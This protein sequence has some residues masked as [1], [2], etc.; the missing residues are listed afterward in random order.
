VSPLTALNWYL[1][2]PLAP[3]GP[4][5]N[6]RVGA[7]ADLCLLDVS[8]AQALSAPDARH[9]RMTWVNGRLVHS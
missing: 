3:G 7:V 8:L 1:A 9:V 6:L 2:D 5:R 4:P